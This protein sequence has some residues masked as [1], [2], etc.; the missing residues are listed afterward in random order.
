MKQE[1]NLDIEQIVGAVQGVL[2]QGEST[3][4][5]HAPLFQGNEWKYVKECI[6]TGWV[7]SVGKYVD[8]FEEKLA[9]YT[10]VK[11]AV[12][13]VNGTAALHM[14]LILAGVKRNDEVLIPALT[15]IATAN[16][17]AY[18]GA[19]PHFVDSAMDTL[20]MDGE[21]LAGYLAEVAE[22]RQGECYNKLTQ[23]RIAAVVPMHTFGH[24]VDIEPLL[25]VCETYRLAFIEDAAESIG[26]FYQGTHTGNFGIVAAMSF[27]GNKTMTTGGGGAILT[28]DVELGNLAKHLT[29]Q[30]KI[31]HQ[32]A[33]RH[34]AVGYNYRMP[35]LNAALGCAQIEQLPCFIAKKRNLAEKYERAFAAVKGVQ[36][37]KEPICS[38]SNYWLNA[39]LLEEEYAN[40]RDVLLEALNQQKIMARPAWDLLY[41]LPMFAGCPRMQ[42]LTAEHISKRLIN[43]PSSVVLG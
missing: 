24:A 40:E 4:A 30:A 5:L 22:V 39:I 1:D 3:I 6:D 2:P 32:W 23:R 17:V 25:A 37:F 28:N 14:S 15:F 8:L 38:T 42:C 9:A 16:A 29:T 12:A 19:I 43:I 7:S 21:K 27:N 20:G 31:P 36:F 18:C 11:R 10:G 26:S 35:N 33:F 34:D 41:T 13:V